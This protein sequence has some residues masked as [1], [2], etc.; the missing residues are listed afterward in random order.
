MESF[1]SESHDMI[2]GELD[3]V[4]ID[5]LLQFIDLL[6]FLLVFFLSVLLL[7]NFMINFSLD[8]FD[9]IF[10]SSSTKTAFVQNLKQ[11]FS[12]LTRNILFD[13]TL[14]KGINSFFVLSFS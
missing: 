7:L 14:D 13:L 10:V 5:L 6:Y 12:L 4:I 3:K 2:E 9:L 11:L 8:S 1:D